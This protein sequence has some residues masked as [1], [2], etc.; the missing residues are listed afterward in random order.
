MR[1][2]PPPSDPE[3]GIFQGRAIAKRFV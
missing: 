3:N 2:A 1:S